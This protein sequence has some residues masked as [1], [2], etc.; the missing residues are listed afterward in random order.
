MTTVDDR[1]L[2]T[3]VA[4]GFALVI[5]GVAAYVL[6]DFASV[7]AL[8]PAIFGILCVGLGQ[9]GLNTDRDRL[10]VYGLGLLAVLGI[11]GS[12]RAVGDIVALAGGESVDSTAAVLAQT[13]MIGLCLVLLV[14]VA[15]ALVGRR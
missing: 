14:T 12:A 3:G 15:L 9:L 11:G 6:T 7:T 1:P 5:L 8:I 2:K 13:G 4:V 10:A